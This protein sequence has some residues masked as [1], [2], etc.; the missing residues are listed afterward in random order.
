MMTIGSPAP[1]Q[2]PSSKQVSQTISRPRARANS[3]SQSVINRWAATTGRRRN[4]A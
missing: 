1:T 3:A 2:A 4:S